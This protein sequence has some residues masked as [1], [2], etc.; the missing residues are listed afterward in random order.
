MCIVNPDL[1]QK[2][3]PEEYGREFDRIAELVNE[4][5]NVDFD[6]LIN[7]D[8]PFRLEFMNSWKRPFSHFLEQPRHAQRR[9]YIRVLQMI[10]MFPAYYQRN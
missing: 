3:T 4:I 10:Y 6:L 2:L 8:I 9:E 1:Y 7:T 5:D